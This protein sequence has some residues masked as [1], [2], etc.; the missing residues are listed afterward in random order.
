MSLLA[1]ASWDR[2][3]TTLDASSVWPSLTEIFW[4]RLP[5]STVDKALSGLRIFVQVHLFSNWEKIKY[6]VKVNNKLWII[7]D[8]LSSSNEFRNHFTITTVHFVYRP[9][10]PLLSHYLKFFAP[11]A[12]TP[13]TPDRWKFSESLKHHHW[14]VFWVEGKEKVTGVWREWRNNIT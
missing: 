11:D 9:P 5:L 14:K 2:I 10:P 4:R 3:F 1:G 6:S 7:F 8:V 12:L 13:T